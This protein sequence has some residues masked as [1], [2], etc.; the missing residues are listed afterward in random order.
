[1]IHCIPIAVALREAHEKASNAEWKGVPNDYWREWLAI[2][3]AMAR[4][5]LWWP[6]F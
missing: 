4:G 5:Q 1:M 6:E 3:D 2:R